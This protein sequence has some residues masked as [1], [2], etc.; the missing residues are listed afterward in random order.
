MGVGGGGIGEWEGGIGEWEGGFGEW[1][2]G[3]GFGELMGRW[4]W[5]QGRGGG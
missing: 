3:F 2:G 5:E 4:W 1:G